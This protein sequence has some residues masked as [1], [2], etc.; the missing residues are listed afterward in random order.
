MLAMARALMARPRL[1]LLDEPS[2]GLAPKI[3]DT[4][5]ALIR[6]INKRG[7]TILL[8]EQ[9]AWKALDLA[10]FAYVIEDGKIHLEGK[11]RELLT[12]PLIK[13]SYLGE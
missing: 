8:V 1:L 6:Q 4:V 5:F 10:D 12:N 2:L 13:H 7:I 3:I 11:G 9:N